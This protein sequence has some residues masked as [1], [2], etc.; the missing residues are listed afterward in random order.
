[1]PGLENIA[2]HNGWAM[3][4]VG[5]SIVF[6]GLIILSFVISQLH[7]ILDIVERWHPSSRKNKN[8]EQKKSLP[9]N[10]LKPPPANSAAAA[11][12][13]KNLDEMIRNYKMIT[14]RL[15]EPFSLPKLLDLAEKHGLAKPYSTVNML[16]ISGIITADDNG[17]YTWEN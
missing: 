9:E 3:A 6:S 4:A 15:G 1:L 16:I 14:Q 13:I 8:R 7:R 17:F 10:Q 12:G 5:I 11:K 2:A